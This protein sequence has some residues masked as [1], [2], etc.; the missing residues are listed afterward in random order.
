MSDPHGLQGLLELASSRGYAPGTD[1]EKRVFTH[2]KAAGSKPVGHGNSLFT[3]Q[4]QPVGMQSEKAAWYDGT[5]GDKTFPQ[6]DETPDIGVSTA[7]FRRYVVKLVNL[8]RDAEF[9]GLTAV[10]VGRKSNGKL[11]AK[12]DTVVCSPKLTAGRR[13]CVHERFCVVGRRETPGDGRKV[14]KE[15]E[16]LLRDPGAVKEDGIGGVNIYA[17]A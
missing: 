14:L 4:P 13:F 10:V 7:P 2:A 11:V 15:L 6:P 9:N 5:A 16:K 1:E 12:F 8:E 3:P 17:Q